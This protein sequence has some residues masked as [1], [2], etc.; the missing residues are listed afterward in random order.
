LNYEIHIRKL[1]VWGTV[2]EDAYDDRHRNVLYLE[3]F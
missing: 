2:H 3:L 1:S